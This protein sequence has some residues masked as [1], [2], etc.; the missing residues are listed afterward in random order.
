M[1]IIYYNYIVKIPA[2]RFDLSVWGPGQL[3]GSGCASKPKVFFRK[4]RVTT[5][6]LFEFMKL[7]EILDA[8]KSDGKLAMKHPNAHRTSVRRFQCEWN[9]PSKFGAR[10]H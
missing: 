6:H 3:L 4:P 1:V 10:L 8:N 9:E 7:M 5:P 2:L